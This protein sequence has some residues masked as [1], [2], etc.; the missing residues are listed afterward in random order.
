MDRWSVR[1]VP[2]FQ[3]VGT[4]GWLLFSFSDNLAT[5]YVAFFLVY[6]AFPACA[7]LQSG[8]VIGAW[9]PHKAR[10]RDGRRRCSQQPLWRGRQCLRTWHVRMRTSL[11]GSVEV[12]IEQLKHPEQP[13]VTRKQKRALDALQN[14]T[15]L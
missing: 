3:I 10:P 14:A 9:F 1:I 7:L 6:A 12:S 8:K 2:V 15:C 4:L 11:L 13:K 5:Y